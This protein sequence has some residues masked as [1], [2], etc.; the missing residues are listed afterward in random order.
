MFRWNIRFDGAAT[1]PYIPANTLLKEMKLFQ[2]LRNSKPSDDLSASSYLIIGLGNPGREYQKNR[3]N[4]G[5][6]AIDVLAERLG[7]T[8]SRVQHKALVADIRHLGNKLILAKPQTFMNNSGQAVGALVR[9]YKLPMS[10]IIVAYDD[11]DLP[12]ETMRLRPNGGSAGQ[13]GMKSLIQHLGTEEFPRI[14]L[15]IGRPPGRMSTPDYVLQNFPKSDTEALAIFLER[16]AD[17]IMR[18]IEEGLEPTMNH[19]NRSQR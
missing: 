7:L 10:N 11:V 4:I 6:M 17:A 3:H 12:F 9:F 18:F 14:R 13:K 1:K 15:G 8:F 16:A 2:R 19:Y 5:F